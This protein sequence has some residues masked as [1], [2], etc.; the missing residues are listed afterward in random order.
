VV[1]LLNASSISHSYE[2]GERA[3]PV[4]ESVPL[5]APSEFPIY[6]FAADVIDQLDLALDQLQMTDRNFDR[7]ACMLID[8]A[9]ELNS[10]HDCSRS[11]CKTEALG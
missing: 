2:S 7:F 1:V 4:R 5:I 9:M 8:N 6:Q 3:A 11:V 10:S